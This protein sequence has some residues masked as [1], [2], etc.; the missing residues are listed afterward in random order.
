MTRTF[1]SGASTTFNWVQFHLHAPSENTVDGYQYDMEIHFVHSTDSGSLAVLGVFFDT[2]A[3]GNA[4][5][6][7]LDEWLHSIPSSGTNSWADRDVPVD[8]FLTLL[9]T[10]DFWS[11]DGSLTTP[12]C[13]EGVKWAVLKEVQPIS[14][15]QLA[16]LTALWAGD[17]T[18]A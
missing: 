13:S 4:E 1:D 16:T 6:L 17:S 10:Q 3:G 7:F 8:A 2:V 9:N 12:P 14:K 11:F 15:A 5:N 18:F